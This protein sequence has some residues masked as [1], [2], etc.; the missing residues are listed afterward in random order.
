MPVGDFASGSVL[1]STKAMEFNAIWFVASKM[2]FKGLSIRYLHVIV[3]ERL[4]KYIIC[5]APLL[6][7]QRGEYKGHVFG[8][9]TQIIT[10]FS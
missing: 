1:T 7:P 5:A 2:D 6:S 8:E 9:Y 4:N 3:S 10:L